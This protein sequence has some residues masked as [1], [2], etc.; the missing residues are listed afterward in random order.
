MAFCHS[1]PKRLA[2]GIHKTTF[3]DPRSGR[4]QSSEH[5]RNQKS[6]TGAP[7]RDRLFAEEMEKQHCEG[8]PHKI[9]RHGAAVDNHELGRDQ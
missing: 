6:D 7:V 8:R 5:H 9:G 4:A 3:R 1:A 2:N